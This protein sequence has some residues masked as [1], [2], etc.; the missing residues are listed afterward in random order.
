MVV[1]M[2]AA[3]GMYSSRVEYGTRTNEA[4]SMETKLT[5]VCRISRDA[6]RVGAL[7]MQIYAA[8][9]CLKRHGEPLGLPCQKTLQK[10]GKFYPSVFTA[11]SAARKPILE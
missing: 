1:T 5:G 2:M 6:G 7:V 8:C 3:T 4:I 9:K 11:A 10:M